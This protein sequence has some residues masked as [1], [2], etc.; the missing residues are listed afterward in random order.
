MLK[1]QDPYHLFQSWYDEYFSFIYLFLVGYFEKRRIIVRECEIEDMVQNT[2]LAI[3]ERKENKPIT[4]PLAYLKRTAVSQARIFLEKQ[5]KAGI[6]TSSAH[7]L[8]QLTVPAKTSAMEQEESE[9]K[10]WTI[11]KSIL[12]QVESKLVFRRVIQGDSYKE[13]AAENDM[14]NEQHLHTI[15][16]RAKV[17]LHD[18]LKNMGY[19]ESQI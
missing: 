18:H 16:H 14:P 10:V 19:D 11:I 12:N 6:K 7:L 2:F 3:L 5:Q 1:K 9:Q 13:I 4:Y 17:K 15:Y 8:N